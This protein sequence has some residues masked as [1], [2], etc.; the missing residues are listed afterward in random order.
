MFATE[1]MMWH[2]DYNHFRVVGLL[3]YLSVI[4]HR[5]PK[6]TRAPSGATAAHVSCGAPCNDRYE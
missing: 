5:A 3:R 4:A 6:M 2:C 1:N